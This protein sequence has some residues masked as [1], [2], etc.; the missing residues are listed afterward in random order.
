MSD[1]V[2]FVLLILGGLL[3]LLAGVGIVRMPDTFT[4]LQAAAKASTLGLA[5][6]LL[7]VAIHDAELAVVTRCL[8][9]AGFV[10]LTAP[11]SAHVVAR[12]ASVLGVKMWEGTVTDELRRD[13]EAAAE[14][15][16][17]KG[18]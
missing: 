13:R 5:A 9:I 17:A 14:R 8:L 2:S 7:G 4:R 10:F 6:I 18:R 12:A 16:V 1:L 15:E 3:V 11:V